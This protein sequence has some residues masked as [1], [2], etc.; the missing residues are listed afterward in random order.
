[1][2][3]M[4]KWQLWC[5]R[6]ELAF[7]PPRTSRTR[8]SYEDLVVGSLKKVK[9]RVEAVRRDLVQN[10]KKKKKKKNQKKKKEKK[11]TGLKSRSGWND[12]E[13]K[14]SR[15]AHGGLDNE[16]IKLELS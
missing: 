12:E 8:V 15:I 2:E 4:S 10:R 11:E 3:T 14:K 6:Y 5:S 1:L 9:K 13:K 16:W 7:P